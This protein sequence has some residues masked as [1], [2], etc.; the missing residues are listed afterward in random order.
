MVDPTASVDAPSS[1]KP[2][3][4]WVQ[5]GDYRDI[6]YHVVGRHRED[7]HQPTR[8]SQRIPSPDA[9]RAAR[10]FRHRPRR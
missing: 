2:G 6:E 7:H 8:G 3:A 4:D 10:S 9:V 5:R 1:V